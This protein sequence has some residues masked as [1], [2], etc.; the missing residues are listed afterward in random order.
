[1]QFWRKFLLKLSFIGLFFFIFS[2]SP[3]LAVES[4]GLGLFPAHP[5]PKIPYSQAW[6]IYN[7]VPGESR[8]DAFIVVNKGDKPITVKLYP[9]D[10]VTTKDGSF[11]LKPE[12]VSRTGVGAWVKLSTNQL[13]VPAKGKKV[14]NFIFSVPKKAEVGDHMGGIIAEKLNQVSAKGPLKIKTR[15]GLRIYETVPG[16]LKKDLEVN[17]FKVKYANKSKQFPDRLIL[18]FN[19][20]NKGNV[21][22]N[23]VADLELINNLNGHV[24]NHK[25][26]V[27]GAVF[28]GGKTTVPVTWTKIPWFGSFVVRAKIKY[29]QNDNHYLTKEARV[30][31]ISN[32][33]KFLGL[34]FGVLALI[35]MAFVAVGREE[36]KKK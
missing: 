2:Q 7:L 15:I 27:L 17:G 34:S 11:A 25:Q 22:L 6:L 14:V 36:K 18:T 8:R 10:A 31:Y 23:P 19:L 35:F 13:T 28:P 29:S 16:Q 12:T 1:M 5:N 32:R 30:V 9:V 24:V 21:H 4:G 20:A 26:A 33:A 3:V